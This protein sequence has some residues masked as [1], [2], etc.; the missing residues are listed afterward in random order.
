MQVIK[1]MTPDEERQTRRVKR[2]A[3]VLLFATLLTL[4]VLF[5]R[6]GFP[7]NWRTSGHIGKFL[8]GLKF[9]WWTP[10]SVR[11]F[12][13]GFTLNMSL[14]ALGVVSFTT[15]ELQ[16]NDMAKGLLAQGRNQITIYGSLSH[17][18]FAI[19]LG[20]AGAVF[21]IRYLYLIVSRLI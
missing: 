4:P 9:D 17:S 20:I 21:S 5:W 13:V 3:A 15:S 18:T 6:L 11:E 2:I 1:V 16:N 19:P 8:S 14:I 12:L 7:L 10:G